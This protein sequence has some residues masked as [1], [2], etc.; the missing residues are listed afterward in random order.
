MSRIL[1]SV[2]FLLSGVGVSSAQVAVY[3][4]PASPDSS[5][6]AGQSGAEAID[7]LHMLGGGL[8]VEVRVEYFDPNLAQTPFGAEIQLYDNPT[9]NDDDIAFIG[10]PYTVSGLAP[11]TGT[12]VFDLTDLPAVGRDIWIGVRFDSPTAGVRLNA[13]PTVGSSHDLYLEE[14]RFYFF[15]GDP[16]AN[17]AVRVLATNITAVETPAVRAPSLRI[18]ASPNPFNP[19]TLIRLELAREGHLSV[20]IVD[21]RGRRVRSLADGFRNAGETRLEWNGRDAS[22]VPAPSGVY[23]VLA[24]LDGETQSFKVTLLK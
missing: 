11:G 8:L 13:N 17:F 19:R 15:G 16:V 18:E 2:F 5:Y 14:G 7:D 1:A 12:A 9:G 20:E 23:H 22:G 10:A 21:V 24:T 6:Y 3:D 4:N